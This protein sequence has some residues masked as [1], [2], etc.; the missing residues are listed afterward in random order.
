MKK[1]ISK[2]IIVTVIMILFTVTL[3]FGQKKIYLTGY[4]FLTSTG[5]YTSFKY[6]RE[7]SGSG[8]EFLTTYTIYHPA[9][10]T[11]S[12]IIKA[13]HNVSQKKITV[14]VEDANGGMF[15]HINTE[16][17]T[18]TTPSLEPF[19]IGGA[20]RMLGGDNVPNQL[21]VK[22]VSSK[23]E[24]IKVCHIAGSH[25]NSDFEFFVLDD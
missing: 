14:T 19:G 4:Q 9:K 2:K 23:Y 6:T 20:V 16:E 17:K 13:T 18:Y 21:M 22:F 10:G 15:A 1:K 3:S 11:P 8:D 7:Y 12:V 24:N 5:Q 25:E